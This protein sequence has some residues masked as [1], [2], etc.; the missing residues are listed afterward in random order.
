M[1]IMMKSEAGFSV[2]NH[3]RNSS[4]S[5]PELAHPLCST[6]RSFEQ[7]SYGHQIS[8]QGE[9]TCFLYRITQMA[10]DTCTMYA[11][12]HC[13]CVKLCF[14]LPQFTPSAL[15]AISCFPVPLWSH[16]ILDPIYTC[17]TILCS[18][19]PVVLQQGS[20]AAHLGGPDMTQQ[21]TTSAASRE[22]WATVKK[23]NL[24]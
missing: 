6:S 13:S 7:R 16:H 20:D 2:H 15:P 10:N 4:C 23:G 18:A 24:L 5:Q 19:N 21:T 17:M 11:A 22:I 3:K 8:G 12:D 14:V 1:M 9:S